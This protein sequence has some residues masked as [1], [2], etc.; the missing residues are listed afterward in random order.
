[1]FASKYPGRKNKIIVDIILSALNMIIFPDKSRTPY[2][3]LV[4]FYFVN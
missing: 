1:M 4:F 3:N 2:L